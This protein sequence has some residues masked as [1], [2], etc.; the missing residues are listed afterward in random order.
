MLVIG[1][2]SGTSADG[3]DAALAEIHEADGRLQLEQ[4]AFITELWTAQE[5]ALI[6]DLFANR[7]DTRTLCLA[8]V[9]LG[10]GFARAA[11]SLLEH[12]RVDP[13]DV[14][15]IGSHGQTVWHEVT[16]DGQVA[17]TLQLGEASVI[18]E[19]TGVTTVADFRVA[20]VAAGGQG[21]PLVSMFDWL[22]LRPD[23]S[24]GG[25]RAVQ[26]IGGIANVTFL[27]PRSL[28][29]DPVAFDTGPG[30]ALIDDAV[31]RLT[32][33]VQTYDRDGAWAAQ[34]VPN[35]ALLDRWLAHPYFHRSPPK[36]TGREL[37]G[38]AL[39]D[40]WREEAQ[41][42]G[43]SDADWVAT[44]TELTA[45][46]I[47]DAYARFAPGPVAEVVVGGGGG[48][49]PVLMERLRSQ[50]AA[51]LGRSVPVRRHRDLDAPRIEDDAKEALAFALLAWL[52]LHG[53]PGNVP[54]CTGAR[55]PR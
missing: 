38:G 55:G 27:P 10:R 3:I 2:M 14:A 39:A 20:D 48:S 51:R 50:L 49:N 31:T 16:P 18:A 47:A 15:A 6:F 44:L 34:G 26:N 11:R 23:D 54:A 17:A 19:E 5:R 29:A 28:D 13:K 35:Q 40:R 4:R 21:A 22:L 45:A 9:Q 42:A 53:R 1:L 43:L 33:G 7:A 46:S 30:N 36:T 24:L 37:F 25:W 8:N 41:A 52:T 32:T 12:A